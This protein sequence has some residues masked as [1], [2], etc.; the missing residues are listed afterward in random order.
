MNISI[1]PRAFFTFEQQCPL[2]TDTKFTKGTLSGWNTANRLPDLMDLD[3]KSSYADV[4]L[5]WSDEGIY[6]GLDVKGAP[7]LE[8]EPKRPLKGDGF[9]VWLDT[10]DVREAH[11]ASRFCHHFYFL[12]TGGRSD[13]PMA[14][15]VRIRRAR[16]Q[17]KICEPQSI[18]VASRVTKKG[19]RLSAF[20]SSDILAGF[21]PED[22]NRFGFTYLLRDRLLDRQ[23]WTADDPLP[24]TYDPSLWGTVSLTR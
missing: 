1:P 12:P 7:G 17:S 24:V 13:G 19:Y 22:N 11:R 23:Y 15:Q 21:E 18:T 8:V 10:R 16:E 6:I 14:G 5:G 2:V 20:L 4:Y 9:Q 3:G